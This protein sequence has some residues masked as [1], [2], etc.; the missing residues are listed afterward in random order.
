MFSNL[1]KLVVAVLFGFVVSSNML[2]ICP[3]QR[4]QQ[5]QTKEAD[6]SGQSAQ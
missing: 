3:C 6:A 1:K 2:A 5:P 4:P